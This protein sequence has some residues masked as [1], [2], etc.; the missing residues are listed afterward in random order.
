MVLTNAD[1]HISKRALSNR[2]KSRFVTPFV[3]LVSHPLTRLPVSEFETFM[4][5]EFTNV[6][7]IEIDLWHQFDME[8]KHQFMAMSVYLVPLDQVREIISTDF[9][10][11]RDLVNRSFV[12]LD[13]SD[14]DGDERVVYCDQEADRY[15][16]C[17]RRVAGKYASCGL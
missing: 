9:P 5:N 8:R 2:E 7:P 16:D 1:P 10:A 4:H 6:D 12:R 17:W 3:S 11:L 15:I 14:L 13:T